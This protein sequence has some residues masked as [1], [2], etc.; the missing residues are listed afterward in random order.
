[1]R[2]VLKE[3]HRTSKLM[4]WLINFFRPFE[5]PTDKQVRFA[6][7]LGITLTPRMSKQD[8]SKAIDQK[9]AYDPEG[10]GKASRTMQRGNRRA[11]LLI[12]GTEGEKLSESDNDWLRSPEARKLQQTFKQWTNLTKDEETYGIIAYRN[13]ATGR[14]EVDV[15]CIGD[16]DVDHDASGT[17]RVVVSTALPDI[18]RDHSGFMTFE[19]AK[20]LGWFPVDNF[21]VWQKLPKSFGDV[22]GCI[23]GNQAE[24]RDRRLYKRY[25]D[26]LKKGRDL[27]KQN[28]I[29]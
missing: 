20:D 29:K 27:V 26:A 10:Y 9:K 18:V 1:M 19:W 25:Q 12:N 21:L 16:A 11:S 6:T 7:S 3:I 14:I 8:V 5:P 23:V 24:A 15:A 17:L 2:G 13:P 22:F 28:G 4:N